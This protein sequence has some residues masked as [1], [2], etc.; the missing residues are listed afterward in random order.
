MDTITLV[1]LILSVAILAV[2]LVGFRKTGNKWTLYIAAA[3]GLFGLSH[4]LTLLGFQETLEAFLIAIRT[5]A[6]L[7]VL[8]TVYRVAFARGRTQ[9]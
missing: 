4:L 3:F 9:E 2:G 8:Y 7:L 1:N 6:Y 5:I